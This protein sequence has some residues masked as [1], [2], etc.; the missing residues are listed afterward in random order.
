MGASV[1]RAISRIRRDDRGVVLVLIALVMAVLM[2][3]AALALDLSVAMNKRRVAQNAADNS[4]LEAAWASCHG[5]DPFAAAGLS[6]T[7]NGFAPTDLTLVNLGSSTFEATIATSVDTFF[8]R[9]LGF[10]KI[11]VT[12][13]AA[14]SCA[15]GSGGANAIFATGTTCPTFSKRQVDISGSNQAVSGGV[16]SNGNAVVSGSTNNFDFDTLDTPPGSI[17]DPFTYLH[18]VDKGDPSN[19]FETGYPVDLDPSAPPSWPPVSPL[20][21]PVDFVSSEWDNVGVDG[22]VANAAKVAGRYWRVNRDIDGSFILSRGDGVYYATGNI[23]LDTTVTADV[24]LVAEGFIE[25]SGSNQV[26]E[27]WRGPGAAANNLLAFGNQPYSG[28]DSCDKFVVS[29]GGSTQSWEGIIYGPNG[30]VEMNGSSGTTFTGSLVGFAVRLNG[31]DITMIAEP[32]FFSGEPFV[33]L[34]A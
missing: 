13:N 5:A 10:S 4:V 17:P 33:R 22:P 25:F 1:R 24:T 2:G 11:D 14:A 26:L 12:T 3:L 28:T 30:L 18:T 15:A 9:V 6:V 8:G 21:A 31:S 32:D 16:H 7:R 27:P 20:P 23:K 29:M 34:E 19:V